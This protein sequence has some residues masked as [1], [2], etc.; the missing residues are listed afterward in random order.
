MLSCFSWC[1]RSSGA[2]SREPSG[3]A[4]MG[5]PVLCQGR[6]A[7]PCT[8][9]HPFSTDSNTSLHQRPLILPAIP[10][11]PKITV[12]WGGIQHCKGRNE[13]Q[14]IF[15]N[16]PPWP[17]RRIPWDTQRWFLVV[18]ELPEREFQVS[19]SS[20][21]VRRDCRSWAGQSGDGKAGRGSHQSIQIPHQSIQIS[22]HTNPYK[23]PIKPYRYLI[24][25]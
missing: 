25:P 5:Q 9:R 7:A 20:S 2:A 10:T 6:T 23:Y 12:W 21:P 8:H 18:P 4:L 19:H 3:A 13:K 14:E 15:S 17:R 11:G 24:N 22:I 1:W 16:D